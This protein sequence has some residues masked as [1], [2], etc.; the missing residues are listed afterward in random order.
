LFV[1]PILDSKE[2][3]GGAC[4]AVFYAIW[5]SFP[6]K[7]REMYKRMTVDLAVSEGFEKALDKIFEK[8]GHKKIYNVI[9]RPNG[10]YELE[11]ICKQQQ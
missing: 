4:Y 11:R 3:L 8:L 10:S 9:Q 5:C 1:S 7:W 2:A 6:C